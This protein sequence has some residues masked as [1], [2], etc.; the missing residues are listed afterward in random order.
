MDG[1][2]QDCR[3]AAA[4]I[5]DD[6]VYWDELFEHARNIVRIDEASDAFV[7]WCQRR[8]YDPDEYRAVAF[9]ALMAVAKDP[10]S[11]ALLL[12]ALERNDQSLVHV[13]IYGL[14]AQRELSALP[15][16]ERALERSRERNECCVAAYALVAYGDEQA[17][18]LAFRFLEED[19]RR[20]YL[21]PRNA[22][23]GQ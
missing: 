23:C 1:E 21:K 11:R 15:A 9:G 10:R 7:T 4:P 20:D 19:E 17:D 2:A 12:E 18:R 22:P 8:L 3:G 16:I 5:P 14:A 13:A 6:G